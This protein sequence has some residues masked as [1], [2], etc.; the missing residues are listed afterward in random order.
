[1]S[2]SGALKTLLDAARGGKFKPGTLLIVESLDRL[3]RQEIST[4]VRLFLDILDTGL[5]IVT[6][7]DGE[8]IFTKERVGSDLTTLIIAVV[9]L[10]RANNESKKR[11]RARQAQTNAWRKARERKI[12]I[13]TR[14]PGFRRLVEIASPL[15]LSESHVVP[16]HS[17]I[18]EAFAQ[19]SQFSPRN[20]ANVCNRNRS[21]LCVGNVSLRR[22]L[23]VGPAR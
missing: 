14:C 23:K 5:V 10:L 1:V 6:L 19:K 16:E 8:Q 18:G 17:P 20:G 12:P 22:N 4:A 9:I 11:E 21:I 7:I 3:S 15:V 13:T 2:D